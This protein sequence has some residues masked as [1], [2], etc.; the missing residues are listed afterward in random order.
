MEGVHLLYKQ[1]SKM[2]QH[3]KVNCKKKGLKWQVSLACAKALVFI[4]RYEASS[5]RTPNRHHVDVERHVHFKCSY[6][7]DPA[8]S[9]I[10]T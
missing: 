3:M 5:I 9:I 10:Q 6:C 4:D 1:V 8:E 2:V 7:A